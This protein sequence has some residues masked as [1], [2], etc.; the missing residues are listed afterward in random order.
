MNWKRE[1]IK[2]AYGSIYATQQMKDL[3]ASPVPTVWDSNKQKTIDDLVLSLPPMNQ[4]A[5]MRAGTARLTNRP[6]VQR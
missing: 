2:M 6:P 1:L 4:L 5:P 3:V